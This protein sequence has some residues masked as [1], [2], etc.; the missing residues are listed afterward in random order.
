MTVMDV[1]RARWRGTRRSEACVVY[2]LVWI[3]K[4]HKTGGRVSAVV[5]I[6]I[7][8]EEGDCRVESIIG[9]CYALLGRKLSIN[10]HENDVYRI[11]F[12]H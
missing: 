6:I 8:S 12:R 2:S 11:I 3:G 5:S 7:A 4:C 1:F 9:G 10:R